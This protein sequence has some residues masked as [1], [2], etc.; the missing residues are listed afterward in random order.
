MRAVVDL[1][2]RVKYA[3]VNYDGLLIATGDH[4][5]RTQDILGGG[6]IMAPAT[7]DCFLL[8]CNIDSPPQIVVPPDGLPR[9]TWSS[10]TKYRYDI[11]SPLAMNSPPYRAPLRDLSNLPKTKG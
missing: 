9:R 2:L 8:H 10:R 1:R 5:W 4:L 7:R 3:C 11:R 6:T